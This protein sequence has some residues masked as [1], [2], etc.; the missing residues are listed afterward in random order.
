MLPSIAAAGLGG[1]LSAMSVAHVGVPVPRTALDT[2]SWLPAST[3]VAGCALASP[4]LLAFP[5]DAPDRATGPG[6]I[7]WAS[8][9]SRCGRRSPAARASWELTLAAVGPEERPTISSRRSLAGAFS[10]EL[11]AVGGSFGWVTIAA[12][13]HGDRVPSGGGLTVV[14]SRATRTLGAPALTEPGARLALARAY[15][16]DVAIA[17]LHDG[18]IVVRVERHYQRGFGPARVIP[19][20]R[21]HVSALIATMDFRSDVLVVWQQNGGV[22]ADMLRASGATDSPQRV[23]PSDPDP[24]LQ[25]L[26]SDNDRGVIAWSG[27]ESS[28]PGKR[29][30]GVGEGR[31]R[32]YVDRSAAGVRFAAPRLL[33]SFADPAEVARSPGSLALVRL[34]SENVLLAWTDA[35]AGHYVVRVAPA[36]F[37]ASRPSTLLSDADAQA[38]LAGVAPGPAG[39]AMALWTSAPSGASDPRALRTQLWAARAFVLPHDRVAHLAPEMLAAPGPIA[40]PSIAVDPADDRALAAWLT[41]GAGGRIEYAVGALP[42]GRASHPAAS[43][44]PSTHTG[45]D[46]LRVV[47]AAGAAALVIA[48]VAVRRRRRRADGG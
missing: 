37:A 2:R 24:Q 34:S 31:A 35:E 43:G 1:L 41:P 30:T 20:P 36:V 5:S 48:A 27:G 4:P 29:G 26:V 15:L 42:S 7:V 21:G 14:Q 9:A 16:G 45:A 47:A 28:S 33:A 8:E 38:V 12:G 19:L 39:E 23:G 22:Y 3:L 6:A 44:A 40:A 18:R 10:G 46:W 11:A 25:A 32:T 13:A 17:T